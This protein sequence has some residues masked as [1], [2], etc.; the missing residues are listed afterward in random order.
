MDLAD[1]FDVVLFRCNTGGAKIIRNYTSSDY[2]HIG[3]V[4]K[5]D[6]EPNEIFLLECT[7]N[8]GVHLKKFSNIKEHIGS[9]YKKIAL[10]HLDFE[11]SEE[12][13]N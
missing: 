7:S 9:F 10:R 1:T 6:C 12:N 4:L 11:R 8:L 3:M 5:F 2:D 13:L